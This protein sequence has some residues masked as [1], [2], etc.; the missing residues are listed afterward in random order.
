VNTAYEIRANSPWDARTQA[1]ARA[2]ADGYRQ[3]SVMN[4]ESAKPGWWTVH[5]LVFR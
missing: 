3:C 5:L 2:K 4:I 1:L